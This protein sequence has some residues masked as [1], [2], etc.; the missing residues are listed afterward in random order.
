MGK[1]TMWLNL[2]GRALKLMEQLDHRYFQFVDTLPRPLRQLAL[3]KNTFE[4]QPIEKPFKGLS[5]MNPLITCPPWLFWEI[6]E[7][8][9]DDIFLQI[10]EAGSIFGLASVLLD[11]II[12]NQTEYPEQVTMLHQEFYTHGIRNFNRVL[13]SNSGFWVEFDRFAS[14][15]ILGLSTELQVQTEFHKLDEAA[16]LR[17][18]HCKVVPMIVPLAALAYVSDQVDILEPIEESLKNAIVAGQLHDDIGDWY[19]DVKNAHMTYFIT[20]IAKPE[21]WDNP[22]WPSTHELQS[23][24]NRNW[25]DIDK[26][27]QVIQWL[28]RALEPIQG[29]DCPAWVFYISEYKKRADESLKLALGEHI[30]RSL[31]PL[32]DSPSQ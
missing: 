3:K 13:P 16:F 6:F 25:I 9:E 8:V 5:E 2:E 30:Q 7:A 20:C 28:D 1:T 14:E 26:L 31:D 17:I 4:G 29:M 19:V 18:A 24:L 11:Q 10:S 22:K 21:Q 12:D 15:H 32:G 27:K 23:Y